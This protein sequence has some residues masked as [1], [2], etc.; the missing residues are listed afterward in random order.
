MIQQQHVLEDLV[1]FAIKAGMDRGANFVTC[2]ASASRSLRSRII[3]G[4]VRQPKDTDDLGMYLVMWMNG[5]V[6]TESISPDRTRILGSLNRMAAILQNSSLPPSNFIPP[7]R[8]YKGG[9]DCT[10][11]K[12]SFASDVAELS[13]RRAVE[14]T[15]DVRGILD[16]NGLILDA[17]LTQSVSTLILANSMGTYQ[18]HS[19]TNLDCSVYAFD[20]EQA[21]TLGQARTIS[22]FAYAGGHS[23]DAVNCEKLAEDVVRKCA[24]QRIDARWNPFKHLSN[25]TGEQYFDVILEPPFLGALLGYLFGYGGFN[26]KFYLE[27]ESFLSGRLGEKVFGDNITIWD[28]P[29]H[30]M[31]IIDPFDWEGK[32][33]EKIL[34]AE[35]GVIKNICYDTTLAC[36]ARKQ[37]ALD[38]L[39]KEYNNHGARDS[40]E[41]WLQEHN[42]DGWMQKLTDY[43]REDQTRST[44][45][46]LPAPAA[47]SYGCAPGNVVIEGGGVN[48]EDMIRASKWPTLWITKVHYLGFNHFQTGTLTGVGQ[49]GVFLI[50][51]G[52]VVGPVENVRFEMPIP[53]ALQRVTHLG[54]PQLTGGGLGG[55]S[56]YVIPPMRI[57]GFRFIGATGRTE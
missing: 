27:G 40:F 19:S 39:Y 54:E 47:M 44:G 9:Y 52:E 43:G 11:A 42:P 21:R 28:D 3:D 12:K 16:A 36:T 22:A 14:F 29:Y 13:N 6:I 37:H 46:A 25:F 53:E 26:G 35:R 38:R 48:I 50:A 31:G 49:H 15:R 34:L 17:V 5:R 24:L 41:T 56:P 23:F 32:P 51:N 33:K 57:E 1:S 18:K 7:D 10:A 30:P 8:A 45:H 55:E 20:R 2:I 4:E